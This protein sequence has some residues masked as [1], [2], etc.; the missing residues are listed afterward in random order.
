[1][2]KSELEDA[3]LRLV[4]SANYQ[5]VK[6]R[7]IAKKLK[8]ADDRMRELRM[9]VKKLAKRG[10][11]SYGQKHV[12]KPAAQEKQDKS[13]VIGTFRRKSSG[14]GFVRPRTVTGSS[15]DE[16]I[17]IP[18][19]RTQDASSGDVVKV[20]MKR[21]RQDREGPSLRGEIVEVLERETHEFVGTYRESSG[22]GEVVIDGNVFK[23]PIYVGDAGA[24][25][26]SP[27]DKVVVE[28]VKFPTHFQDGEGVIVDILGAKGDPGVD[29]K[30]I[31]REFNLPRDFPEDVLDDSREQAAAFDESFGEERVDLTGETIITI[32]PKDARD[33]DD[34]IS[35]E[36]LENGHW[37]LGVHIADVSHF[38][39][40]KSPLDRE[41]RDR[42]TSVYLP[43]QV[44]PMLPEIISNN[45]A[46]LQ[47]KRV[48]FAKTAFIEF[49]PDG[50]RVNS[51]FHNT[52]I[53]SKH[54]FNYEQ[55]DEFIDDREP[56]RE[57]LT[58]G[59]FGLV[60]RMYELAMILRRRRLDG[61]A[62]ELTLPETKIDLDSNG[63]VTGA[64]LVQQTESHQIIEEF[65]LAANEAVAT[66]FNEHELNFL[67]RVH[68][69]P[70]PEKLETLTKFVR[71]LELDCEHMQ[72]RFE[73]K[74]VIAQ[75]SN[76]PVEYAVHFAV[77]RSM[78]KAVYSPEV[79]RHYAL[80][81]DH[82][83]HF[84]S[85][86][87][88]YPDLIV[89]RML[90]SLIAGKR[91]PDDFDRMLTLGDHCSDREQRAEAAERELIKVKLLTFLA[92][93]IG[94]QMDAV[95]TGVE[96]F[97]LFARGIKLPGEGLIHVNSMQ[98]DYYRYDADTH[99]L[100]GNKA[101]NS[102]RLGD[103]I[104]VEIAHVDIDRRELDFRIVKKQDTNSAKTK[105]PKKSSH[106]QE[107]KK[108]TSPTK[109]KGGRAKRRK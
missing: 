107:G 4:N 87:R 8:L 105:T 56:W 102:Y 6:P 58:K 20:R 59:I 27:G 12:V 98:D 11:I 104:N 66:M 34:A 65:M 68:E 38:V 62:I 79:I 24:K 108:K 77:L 100:T 64:H 39:R 44:I 53:K 35:L 36:R 61:G 22:F 84:T 19:R 106:S 48:R 81:S 78:Q 95:V 90:N 63:V 91:P 33:F 9:V 43:D 101:G 32:D 96:E 80:N 23:M 71:D 60:E 74:R 37:R 109:K 21:S 17:F 10:A 3:V 1:M 2:A 88:R 67:R 92:S 83:C 57:K 31:I 73:I 52:A 93:R 54:R 47:P 99:S 82:Y 18:A 28:M 103:L 75:V 86:I 26:A 14:F 25:N 50:V 69:S 45:L 49:T 40:E 94:E 55:I 97:G 29:T 30:S 5:P 7:V 76:T 42:A 51:E 41:A 72:S 16:D 46:S 13:L 89:H 15:R 70:K 85:P